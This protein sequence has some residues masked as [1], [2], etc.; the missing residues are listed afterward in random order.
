MNWTTVGPQKE[1]TT[2]D[3]Q[4]NYQD[5]IQVKGLSFRGWHGAYPEET[6]FGQR[7]W[8]D[9]SLYGDFQKAGQSDRLDDAIDYTDVCETILEIG[10][11]ESVKL[12]ERLATL[13]AETLLERYRVEAVTVEISKTPYGVIGMPRRVSVRITRTSRE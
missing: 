1:E 12:L 3:I 2:E 11:S 9:A 6:E 10:R 5:C 7:M 13:I 8:V 4:L